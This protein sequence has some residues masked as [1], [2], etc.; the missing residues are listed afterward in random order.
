[1][2]PM[3]SIGRTGIEVSCDAETRLA[4]A[5]AWLDYYPPATEI[6]IVGPS[7]EAAEDLYLFIAGLK[8]AWFGISRFT[9]NALAA[10]LAG[11]ALANSGLASAST[12]S[13]VAVVAR[14]IHSLQ[15]EGKLT[16]FAPVATRPGFP[17]A[18]ARTLEELRMNE[19]DAL[20]IERLSNGGGDLNAIA[21]AV[22]GE[23]KGSKL[24]D[25]AVI[26]RTAIDVV[27]SPANLQPLGLPLL[28]LDL[29]PRTRLEIEL[30]RELTLRSP[31]VLATV[32]LGDE[33][34]TAALEAALNCTRNISAAAIGANSLSAAKQHLFAESM[35][36][37]ATLDDSLNLSSW[38][39]EPRE[40][41]EIVRQIQNEAA[42]GVAFDQMAVFLNSSSEYRSHLDEAFNR[43]EIPAYFSRGSTAPDPAGRAM[44]ALLSCA[45]EGLSARRFAEYLSLGQVPDLD[46]PKDLKALWV[47][48]RDELVATGAQDEDAEGT[49]LV[50]TEAES[51]QVEP[52]ESAVIEGNLRAPWRWERL[53]VDSAVIGGKDRWVR[54]LDGLANELRLQLGVAEEEETA[55]TETLSRQ[56]RDLEHLRAFAVPAIELLAALPDQASWGDW[57]SQLR[58]LAVLTVRDPSGVLATLADL[59][60]MAPVGP[61]D[62]Y[63]VQ[64]VLEPRLRELSI[65][66]QRRRYGCVFVGPVESARGLSFDVVFIPGLAE[67]IF[68]RKLIE[69]PILPDRQRQ[70]AAGN[71]LLTRRDRLE[72]ERLALRLAIGAARRRA[73]LSYPRIDVQQSRPRVPSFYALEA[74]RAAEGLLPSFEEL[75]SRAESATRTRLGW[76]APQREA[77]AIDESE[78]DLALLGGLVDA[79]PKSATGSANY[80]LSANPHLAR[81][82][83]ARFR[84]WSRNWTLNDGLVDLDD[85]GKEA[86]AR[87]QLSAR[88]FSSTALQHYA[89]C[90]YRF[91]LSAVF[92]LRPRE[93][94]AAIEVLDP[95][96]R[97]G[98]FHE[99]QFAV[100]TKLKV[101]GLLPLGPN[102]FGEACTLVDGALDK[103]AGVYEDKLAPAIPRV[104]RD[105]IES[106]RADLREW[107]RRASESDE[108][109]VPDQFELAFAMDHIGSQSRDPDSISEPVEIAGGLKLR[110]S[111]DLIERHASGKLRVTDHKTGKAR[112][113]K[114]LIVGGGKSLQPLLYA[115]ACEKLLGRPVESGRLYYCTAAGGYEERVV[116]LDDDSREVITSV[117]ATVGQALA[118]GF[119]PA[120]P[121]KGACGWC[122]FR[123]VCGPLEE[124]RTGRKPG[125][126]LAQLTRVRD[127]P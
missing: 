41:V 111:I 26:F 100:L 89:S 58:V 19:V 114:D 73:Y 62:L 36:P 50:S 49:D 52:E 97:G 12:L 10:H 17:V 57:L 64:M 77:D 22:D 90:P 32:P 46:Q 48:P 113:E 24:A 4:R 91:F 78:Y 116:P 28:L 122:D 37:T 68:P 38:P 107:L 79:E 67:K 44:L 42:R 117:I 88:A 34:V 65:A 25:R 110:G 118:D 3:A 84:R 47:G 11:A 106:L 81:A 9:L 72:F 23:L 126:R 39:G 86:I 51:L 29:Q 35:P 92:R 31:N 7:A 63:E 2:T 105:A 103:V 85:L 59:E 94:V 124:F 83:R 115:L 70:E 43:A 21:Q 121:E 69:D 30:I 99:V 53:L 125:I 55:Y 75:A 127:L 98:L 74:R 54:R 18:V 101:A 8:G 120:A 5:A 87:H 76:P 15:S 95:L 1:M 6:L 109:W 108:G 20:A 123:A 14:A 82:L 60:P 27:R 119:L 13:F 61:V 33:P 71:A 16:Y 80:L 40:C 96:T 56:L 112:A 104:W 45:A 102:S 93:E 66:S